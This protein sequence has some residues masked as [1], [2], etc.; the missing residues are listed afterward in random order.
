VVPIYG[1]S[2]TRRFLR[3]QK[4]KATLSRMTAPT[5]TPT[6]TPMAV[7]FDELDSLIKAVEVGV[8]EASMT[9]VVPAGVDDA[10]GVGDDV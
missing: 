2:F 9:L 4:K 5:P 6:P 3:R 1:S 8:A 10:F 7:V